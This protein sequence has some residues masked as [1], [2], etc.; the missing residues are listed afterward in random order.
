[1]P[2][3]A[4]FHIRNEEFSRTEE[5]VPYMTAEIKRNLCP[6]VRT[7]VSG[8]FY[9]AKYTA[10]WCKIAAATHR[11]TYFAY[12]RSWTDPEILPELVR[13][14]QLP[15][16]CLWFSTDLEMGYPPLVGGVRVAYMA[17]N[18]VDAANAPPEADLVFRDKPTTP[19]KRANGVLVCP[20]ENAV[21]GKLHHTCTSCGIC[22]D[23]QRRPG[24]ESL[25]L[26]LLGSLDEGIPI[27]A[28]EAVCSS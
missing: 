21:K 13:L 4:K 16:V 25:L 10:K 23:R 8:D 22:W 28:P 20:A 1:M 14:S 17:I 5:F 7:H 27:K 3:V 19:M 12:T 2:G 9:D 24:W 26:P 11:T 15:N 18:D 6:V